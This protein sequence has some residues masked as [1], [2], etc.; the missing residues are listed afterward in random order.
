MTSEADGAREVR[1]VLHA[2]G[3]GLVQREPRLP[4]FSGV[5]PDLIAWA[6]DASGDLVPWAAI[7]FKAKKT[8]SPELLL[9]A[10]ARSRDL[11]GTHDHYAV[12]NGQWFK[13]ESLIARL[14]AVQ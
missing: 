2:L 1:D 13:A 8:K 11:L 3:Y 4:G 9:P 5:R 7:E 10:L 14:A 12:I 6:S